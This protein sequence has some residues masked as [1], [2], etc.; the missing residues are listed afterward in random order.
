MPLFAWIGRDGPRGVELRGLHREE[1]LRGLEP[2]D[3]AG[4]IRFA[5]PLL[6]DAGKPAG[7]VIV[8]EA[9]SLAAAR[10]IAGADAYAQR[11]IFASWEV[12]ETRAVFPA[13]RKE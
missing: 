7:S 5:G 13:Q 1:H 10:A 11:G 3:R 4:R 6:D 12:F 9:D 2:L 8:F